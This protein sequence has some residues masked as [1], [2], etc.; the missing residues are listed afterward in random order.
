MW[1]VPCE[2][3]S[4]GIYGQRRLWSDCASAQS[5]LSLRCPQTDSSD[6]VKC[7][8]GEQMPGWEFDMCRKMWI[9]TIC[10]CSKVRYRLRPPI[11]S[12][13]GIKIKG[14]GWALVKRRLSPQSFFFLLIVQRRY[15]CCITS[16]K[17]LFGFVG[18][19]FCD[20]I[21]CH[22]NLI[23]WLWMVVF[24][25]SWLFWIFTYSYYEMVQ[26]GLHLD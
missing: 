20:A 15:F 22:S 11:C 8:N 5:D 1:A 13:S 4:L 25:N 23:R 17:S 3:L 21:S 26:T 18:M 24:S 16:S 7:I 12:W 2:N 10:A 6:T 19:L 9:R 14:A